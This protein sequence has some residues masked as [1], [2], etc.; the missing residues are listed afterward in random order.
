MKILVTGGTTFVSRYTARW[1]AAKGHEVYA[2]NRGSKPQEPGVRHICADRRGDLHKALCGMHFNAVLDICAY[3]GEDVS[4]LLASVEAFDDYILISSS[5]VYPES[6][7][8]PFREDQPVG[9]NTIWGKYGTDKIAAEQAARTIYPKSYILRP[10][11][12]YGPMQ[13]IYREPF[14]FDCALKK[15]PFFLPKDGEMQLQFFHVE[16]LCRVIESI[17]LT[18]PNQHIINV[19]NEECIRIREF[20]RLCYDIAGAPLVYEHIYQTIPQRSYFPFHDYEYRL[21]V[22]TQRQL[23]K[24]TIPITEGLKDSFAWYIEHPNDVLRKD[25]IKFIDENLIKT[26][27]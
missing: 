24:N 4:N 6:N 11:Y 22:T 12:I 9:P 17:L 3:T 19:G 26:D 25:Y 23:L 5:A 21:D 18:H 27:Q 10:P 15:R 16:D 1:F 8:Q 14:V 7:D 2:L 13:N 20:V